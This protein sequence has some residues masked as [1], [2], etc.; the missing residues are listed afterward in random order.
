MT[1]TVAAPVVAV[2]APAPVAAVEAPTKVED[3]ARAAIERADRGSDRDRGKKRGDKK[4]EAAGEPKEFWETW[5][6][7]KT[8]REPAPAKVV[9]ATEVEVEAP[10]EVAADDEPKKGRGRERG[11]GKGRDDKKAAPAAKAD[12]KA[13][14]PDKRD[15][16]ADDKKAAPAPTTL[17]TGA[18]A[19]LFVS[20]GKKHGVTADDLRNL[21]AGPVGGDKARIGSVMLRD[22][23]AHVKVTEGDVDAI[24]GAL[25]GTQH[26][27]HDVTVERARA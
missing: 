21:L 18:D 20:L 8:T 12:V 15:D 7:E 1:A 11:R 17:V 13:G 22:S 26:N 19:K 14:K 3:V 27:K 5:A 10:A 4:P 9:E 25:H 16:K 24:I 23:H 2:T 6:A